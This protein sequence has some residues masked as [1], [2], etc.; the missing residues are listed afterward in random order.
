MLYWAASFNK[1]ESSILEELLKRLEA[2]PEG[3][4]PV[5][6]ART[7]CH[8]AALVGNHEKLKILLSDINNRYIKNRRAEEEKQTL[9]RKKNPCP[10]FYARW[11]TVLKEKKYMKIN[12]FYTLIFE[13][14]LA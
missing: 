6:S 10:S 11:A 13:K 14:K 4:V 1:I 7:P 8:A 5:Y 3:S 2:Y 9:F 12:K